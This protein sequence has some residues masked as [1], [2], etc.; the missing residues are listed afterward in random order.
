M[1][2]LVGSEM[3][4]RD[5]FSTAQRLHDDDP[6]SPGCCIMQSVGTGLCLFVEEVVLDLTKCPL[7]IGVDDLPE[8][9]VGV[10]EGEAQVTDAT[11]PDAF[12]RPLEDPGIAQF[13]PTF[14]AEGVQQVELDMVGLHALQLFFEPPGHVRL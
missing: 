8:N 13:V 3:C 10:M 7:L 14:S 5:Q 1:P 12:V 6:Q 9:C 4:I 11:L 2:S